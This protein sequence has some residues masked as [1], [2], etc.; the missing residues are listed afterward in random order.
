M[1]LVNVSCVSESVGLCVYENT[2][3]V[4]ALENDCVTDYEDVVYKYAS[5]RC[6]CTDSEV[7]Y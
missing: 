6:L 5:P 7:H 2:V 1:K 3:D 4:N